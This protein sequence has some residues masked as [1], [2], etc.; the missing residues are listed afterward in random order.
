MSLFTTKHKRFFLTTLQQLFLENYQ[1][2]LSGTW[3]VFV[4]ATHIFV[5]R[6]D[7]KIKHIVF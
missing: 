6:Y 4:V 3:Q 5:T 2:I 1:F 7:K